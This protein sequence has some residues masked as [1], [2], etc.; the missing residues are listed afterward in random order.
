M[1]C[2][3]IK[4]QEIIFFAKSWILSWIF[5]QHPRNW[6][7]VLNFYEFFKKSFCFVHFLS[8]YKIS[9]QTDEMPRNESKNQFSSENKWDFPLYFHLYLKFGHSFY[10]PQFWRKMLFW[11]LKKSNIKMSRPKGNFATCLSSLDPSWPD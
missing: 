5:C 10:I 4:I 8:S 2:N 6:I 11:L 1:Q 7:F 9:G 3:W